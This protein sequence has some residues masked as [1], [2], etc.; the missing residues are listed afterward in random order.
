MKSLSAPCD[1]S[2]FFPFLLAPRGLVSSLRL[3]APL[4]F[5]SPPLGEITERES[6]LRKT[7]FRSLLGLGAPITSTL[8][9]PALAIERGLMVQSRVAPNCGDRQRPFACWW[10]WGDYKWLR[11]F[12]AGLSRKV[13]NAR[14]TARCYGR[15]ALKTKISK[16]PS[17]ALPTTTAPLR[18]VISALT[19]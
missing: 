14:R 4:V 12:A 5:S 11:T 6:R 1:K 13:F 10:N 18:L 9:P 8:L 16:K 7:F 15:W 19:F 3:S 2:G 17:S